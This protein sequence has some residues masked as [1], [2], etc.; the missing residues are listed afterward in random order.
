MSGQTSDLLRDVAGLLKR[1]P[2]KEWA[3][4][5]ELLE[6]DAAR[7]QILTLLREAS[8]AGQPPLPA[9]RKARDFR[10]NSA[11]GSPD[12]RSLELSRLSTQELREMSR[13]RGLGYSAKDSRQRLIGRLLK[14]SG[15]PARPKASRAPQGSGQDS[16]DYA[17]WADIIMGRDKTIP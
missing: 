5:A 13:R 15:P 14:A 11:K 17:K 1:H 8:G 6:N 10:G 7:S 4:L 2:A 9:P 16:G 3:R 12:R